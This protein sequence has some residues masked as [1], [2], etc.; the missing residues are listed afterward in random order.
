MTEA[1]AIQRGNAFVL[2]N[3]GVVGEPEYVQLVKRDGQRRYWSLVYGAALFFPEEIA[4]GDS[5]DGCEYMVRVDDQSG[6]V[7]LFAFTG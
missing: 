1:D 2:K 3:R 4:A 6:D 5:I 7:S